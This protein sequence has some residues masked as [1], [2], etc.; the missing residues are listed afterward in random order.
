M[1]SEDFGY[2]DRAFHDFVLKMFNVNRQMK[3]LLRITAKDKNDKRIHYQS[4]Q[5]HRQL[6][7]FMPR[8]HKNV[9]TNFS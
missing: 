7:I 6:G 4:W 1:I 2:P 3:F 8:K 5:K 9:K